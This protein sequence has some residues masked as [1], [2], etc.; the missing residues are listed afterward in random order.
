[1]LF[2]P[3]K[4][5]TKIIG[6]I[7]YSQNSTVVYRVPIARA[8]FLGYTK[9]H[10]KLVPGVNMAKVQNSGKSRRVGEQESRRAGEQESRRAGDFDEMDMHVKSRGIHH[11]MSRRRTEQ[12]SERN[13][14]VWL[15]SAMVVIAIIGVV[16][17]LQSGV[18]NR[19]LSETALPSGVG[20]EQMRLINTPFSVGI[21]SGQMQLIKQN[22]P[23]LGLYLS[24]M[25]PDLAAQLRLAINR[26]VYVNDVVPLSPAET[27]GIKPGDVVTQL[28][29]TD[30]IKSNVVGIVLSKHL[31]GDVVQAIIIRNQTQLA[32]NIRLETMQNQLKSF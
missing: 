29:G 12:P 9:L 10:E 8:D 3:F 16:V 7:P 2:K 23:F 27:A 21:G 14:L 32:T 24:D 17:V 20:P 26:G 4:G 15:V 11:R 6:K 13:L 28:D 5:V 31:P 1:M 30:L 22:T 25:S 19:R 18:R